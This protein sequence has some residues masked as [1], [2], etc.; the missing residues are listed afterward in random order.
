MWVS[1]SI[2]PFKS[3]VQDGTIAMND[4]FLTRLREPP[5]PEFAA[6]LYE[7][8]SRPERRPSV[9]SRIRFAGAAAAALLVVLVL[10]L[11]SPHVR[12]LAQEVLRFFAPAESGSFT[13][14]LE[15]S[16]GAARADSS[17]TLA[18]PKDCEDGLDALDYQCAVADAEAA[19]G[20]DVRK[21]PSDPRGVVFSGVYADP[22]KEVVRQSYTCAGCELTITQMHRGADGLMLDS[23]WSEVPADAVEQVEVNG[24]P[25]EYAQGSFVS[26]D[27]RV[28]VWE[29][30]AA[31]QRLRWREGDMLFEIELG[32]RTEAVEYLGKIALIALAESLR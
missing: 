17:V 27:S 10:L 21:L 20:F 24:F 32:G 9:H 16:G 8:I 11:T 30:D 1:S 4:D 23:A 6:S 29:A 13:L 19:V 2:V 15:S 18:A 28:A 5:R 22:G 12:A 3:C 31:R 14:P 25:G 26:R 7:R